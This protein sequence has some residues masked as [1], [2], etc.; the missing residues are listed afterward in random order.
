M[1]LRSTW[2]GTL[3][4]LWLSVWNVSIAVA[5]TVDNLY[6]TTVTV[7]DRSDAGRERAFVQ[8]LGD[9]AIRISGTRDAPARLGAAAGSAKRYVQRFGY[10]A[11]DQL[12]VGFDPRAVDELLANAGLSIW[13]R[14]RPTTLVWLQTDDGTG[15]RHMVSN[16]APSPER[17]SLLRAAALRGVPLTWAT[18]SSALESVLARQPTA[19]ELDAERE[20]LG[21]D[22]LL[23]GYATRS[24]PQAQPTVRWQLVFDGQ[25]HDAAGTVESGVDLAADSFAKMFAAASGSMA[26][27]SVEVDGITNL[28]AYAQTLN[29]LEGLTLVRSVGVTEVRGETVQFRVVSRGDAETLRRALSLDSRLVPQSLE[30]SAPDP[31]RLRLRFQA[32]R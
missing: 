3:F 13:G 18:S 6:I 2:M 7:T 1:D 15:A 14:E 20:R 23:I 4:V 31:Q 26:D 21:V 32:A 22:A 5:A 16:A 12:Q 10:L 28:D 8:A 19:A 30:Q 27:L 17:D 25:A 29:Y 11:E 9:V 24:S